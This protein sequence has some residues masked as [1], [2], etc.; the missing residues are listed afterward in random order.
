M[1]CCAMHVCSIS[2]GLVTLGEGRVCHNDIAAHAAVCGSMTKPQASSSEGWRIAGGCCVAC[3]YLQENSKAYMP[4]RLTYCRTLCSA[5]RQN[6]SDPSTPPNIVVYCCCILHVVCG[7][8]ACCVFSSH[9]TPQHLTQPLSRPLYLPVM[10]W[11]CCSSLRQ[12][13]EA[14]A[15]FLKSLHGVVQMAAQLQ[16][17]VDQEV[18]KDVASWQVLQQ[19]QALRKDTAGLATT[20][21]QQKQVPGSSGRACEAALEM[22]RPV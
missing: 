4:S 3:M 6:C 18:P 7:T 11:L 20:H 22:Q 16:Q 2:Q 14:E 1:C 8:A 9:P 21:K 12:V 17:L 13:A 15:A 5:V 10:P 19:T